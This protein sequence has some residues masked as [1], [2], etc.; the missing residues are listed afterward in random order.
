MRCKSKIGRA[1]CREIYVDP[2][3]VVGDVHQ[4]VFRVA[5]G[6]N[7][8]FGAFEGDFSERGHGER[9][10]AFVIFFRGEHVIAVI[11]INGI[12]LEPERERYGHRLPLIEMQR[13]AF[14]EEGERRAVF[15]K[16][17]FRKAIDIAFKVGAQ[18]RVVF[19]EDEGAFFGRAAFR[20]MF[21]PI[22]VH[23]AVVIS[24][25][26]FAVKIARHARGHAVA[27]VKNVPLARNAVS[28]IFGDEVHFGKKTRDAFDLAERFADGVGV[29]FAVRVNGDRIAVGR[30]DRASVGSDEG[31]VFGGERRKS[32]VFKVVYADAVIA[33]IGSDEQISRARRADRARKTVGGRRGGGDFVIGEL[34]A[35]LRY[36]DFFYRFPLHAVQFAVVHGEGGKPIGFEHER[37]FCAVFGAK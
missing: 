5:R 28:V 25:V 36:G 9:R 16:C 6:K 24:D 15:V 4:Q 22:G 19:G 14:G 12:V 17:V 8:L 26:N 18:A 10:V 1:S 30:R 7:L 33:F 29:R 20:E 13:V 34:R 2:D 32:A 31:D 35:L 27:A 3:G 11:E 37:A 21:F 23:A